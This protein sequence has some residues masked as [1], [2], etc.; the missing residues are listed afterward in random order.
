MEVM[1]AIETRKSIRGYEDKPVPE[2]KL[3]K[4]LEAARLSPSAGNRQ[5]RKFVVVRDSKLRA[6]LAEATGGQAFI[7]EAPVVI[8]AVTTMPDNIMRCDVPSYPVDLAIAVDHMTLAAVEEGLG[9]CWICGFSQQ[10]AMEAVGVPEK[11]KVVA[12]LPLGFPRIEGKDK[13][14]KTL[15]EMVCYETFKE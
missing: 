10:K 5:Y 14:R 11:Y 12:L 8:V 15:E 3:N 13:T 2:E 7:A 4:V 6:K 1:E 9:T